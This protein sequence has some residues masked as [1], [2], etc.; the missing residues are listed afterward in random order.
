MTEKYH[1][2]CLFQD[3]IQSPPSQKCKFN[4]GFWYLKLKPKD[5]SFW[6][7]FM[8]LSFFKRIDIIISYWLSSGQSE[9]RDFK[10]I[11]TRFSLIIMRWD[12]NSCFIQ[13]ITNSNVTP[14]ASEPWTA[15]NS[16]LLVS[17]LFCSVTISCLIGTKSQKSTTISSHDAG[18]WKECS[19][20]AYLPGVSV[21]LVCHIST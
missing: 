13:D 20:A 6:Q 14:A 1:I 8:A 15:T 2:S 11:I 16:G 12:I 18:G 3:G 10:L 17:M 9:W 5:L 4:F 19:S 21:H 7:R